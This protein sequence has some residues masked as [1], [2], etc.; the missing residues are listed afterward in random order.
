M[1]P[2]NTELGKVGNSVIKLRLKGGRSSV[3]RERYDAFRATDLS[4]RPVMKPIRS[5]PVLRSKK[6]EKLHS[7]AG[8][9]IDI[10][11]HSRSVRKYASTLDKFTKQQLQMLLDKRGAGEDD[12]L[13]SKTWDPWVARKYHVDRFVTARK[14][15]GIQGAMRTANNDESGVRDTWNLPRASRIDRRIE[16][17]QLVEAEMKFSRKVTRSHSLLADD[18][19]VSSDVELAFD[20]LLTSPKI[21]LSAG[22]VIV[23]MCCCVVVILLLLWKPHGYDSSIHKMFLSNYDSM[24]F[25]KL[26]SMPCTIELENELPFEVIAVKLISE[27][28]NRSLTIGWNASTEL[29]GVWYSSNML[30]RVELLAGVETEFIGEYDIAD[31]LDWGDLSSLEFTVLNGNLDAIPNVALVVEVQQMSAWARHKIWLSAVLLVLVYVLIGLELFDR[32][33]IAL[34]GSFVALL[35]VTLVQCPP[36]MGLVMTWMDEGTL[37]LLFGMMVIVAMLSVT[38]VFEWFAVRLVYFSSTEKKDIRECNMFKLTISMCIF[39]A[40][41]SAFLDNVTTLL[42]ISPVS[43]CLCNMLVGESACQ[44]ESSESDMNPA[45]MTKSNLDMDVIEVNFVAPKSS[46]RKVT[47][48]GD[49]QGNTALPSPE[50]EKLAVPLLIVNGVFGNIGGCMTLIGAIP[51]VIVGGRLSEY[52]GFTDFVVN[53]APAVLIMI[54]LVVMFVRHRFRDSLSGSYPV[55]MEALY[56]KYKIKDPQ[57]LRRAGTVTCFVIIAFFLHPVHHRSSGWLA[58]IGA[59]GVLA[60]GASKDVSKVLHHVEWD[61]LIFFGGLFVLVAA[62]SELGLIREI[63]SIIKEIVKSSEEDTRLAVACITILWVSA[64]VSGFLSNIAF[65]ATMAPVI[66]IVGED[67]ELNLPMAPLAWSLCFGTCLGGNLTLI[68]SAANLIAAGVA[69]H[70][71]MHISFIEF[72]KVGAPVWLITNITAMFWLLIVYVW[73]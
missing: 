48:S 30:G 29:D 21:K 54:P 66:K 41:V 73:K 3:N 65:A 31:V 7:R 13:F 64:L 68:G 26:C 56:D 60:V 38:G 34:I 40:I 12:L 27:D 24:A 37:S 32:V 16:R 23:F 35:L 28:V 4:K 39:S 9:S 62:L 20:H 43:I 47:D 6:D 58:V 11:S 1:E 51:N 42:L 46:K 53:L 59:M 22:D 44:E 33:L 10:V 71:G 57:L 8:G 25:G 17:Q 5:V 67:T 49:L 70:N 15:M 55:D 52:I 18:K 50:V 2:S 69:Q 45:K 19:F 72:F 61:T 14:S 63:G 36:D